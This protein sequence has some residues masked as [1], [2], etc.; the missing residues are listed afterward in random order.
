M[1][2]PTPVS[3]FARP[4]LMLALLAP[5]LA[6]A[7]VTNVYALPYEF[8]D[9]S[10][11]T[12]RLSEWKGK[13]IVVAMDHSTWSAVCS[14]TARRLRAIQIAAD[15]LDQEVEFVIIGIEPHK[16]TPEAW[17]EYRKNRRISGDNWTFLRASE[18][19]TPMVAAGLGVRYRYEYDDVVLDLRILRVD[20]AGEV[21]RLMEGYDADTEA[22][23]R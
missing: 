23:L 14:S 2:R 8:T 1:T 4:L 19:D 13:P 9:E 7:A 11:A 20:G 22:F 10:G 17:A 6:A 15:R 21:V 3:L 5:A 16:D 18:T 12:R